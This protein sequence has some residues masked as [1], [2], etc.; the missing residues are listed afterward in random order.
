[1][2]IKPQLIEWLQA[3]PSLLFKYVY[4]VTDVTSRFLRNS[5]TEDQRK[6]FSSLVPEMFTVQLLQI[7]QTALPGS[8][9]ELLIQKQVFVQLNLVILEVIT[10]NRQLFL[11]VINFELLSALFV[12]LSQC[13]SSMLE[14]SKCFDVS[15]LSTQ[16]VKHA[17]MTTVADIV[18]QQLVSISQI[19]LSSPSS[20]SSL[21]SSSLPSSSN[22]KSKLLLSSLLA[23]IETSIP[24]ITEPLFLMAIWLIPQL[25]LQSHHD[26]TYTELLGNLIS[27]IITF[28]NSRLSISPVNSFATRLAVSMMHQTVRPANQSLSNIKTDEISNNSRPNV[29]QFCQI[30]C[31]GND[32]SDP[33]LLTK[34]LSNQMSKSF[35]TLRANRSKASENVWSYEFYPHEAQVQIT[36]ILP[37]D[38]I[39]HKIILNPR[40]LREF[41]PKF[42]VIIK[43]DTASHSTTNYQQIHKALILNDGIVIDHIN[44]R[45]LS[46]KIIM[47]FDKPLLSKLVLQ[48][49]EIC[50][51]NQWWDHRFQMAGDVANLSIYRCLHLLNHVLKNESVFRQQSTYETLLENKQFFSILLSWNHMYSIANS[52]TNKLLIKNSSNLITDLLVFLGQDHQEFSIIILNQILENV[53]LVSTSNS[54]MSG[55]PNLLF[56]NEI[57]IMKLSILYNLLTIEDQFCMARL[58]IVI[59]WFNSIKYQNMVSL[60]S[61]ASVVYLLSVV[62]WHHYHGAF[63]DSVDWSVLF[64]L[65][66]LQRLQM[67]ILNSKGLFRK[68][69]YRLLAS[70]CSLRQSF[71]AELIRVCPIFHGDTQHLNISHL[72]S[73]SWATQS[74]EGCRSLLL[75]GILSQLVDRI[76]LCLY[77]SSASPFNSQQIYTEISEI[78]RFFTK[79]CLAGCNFIKIWL[80]QSTASSFWQPIVEYLINYDH[81]ANLTQASDFSS[82]MKVELVTAVVKFFSAV[83]LCC[84]DNQVVFIRILINVID[85]YRLRSGGL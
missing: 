46:N 17:Q 82:I 26:I 54:L 28:S 2:C 47:R 11:P 49:I 60:D 52:P 40:S 73:I 74:S 25:S 30:S 76:S 72:K 24:T 83:T 3:N 75:S 22:K 45:K 71:Y 85:K 8:I 29:S 37:C 67:A 13:N 58:D 80:G 55:S 78:L 70:V 35:S 62:I 42:E 36:I 48:K 20:S 61:I 64:D 19:L 21:S 53:S 51:I 33:Y 6:C 39:V 69:L 15:V 66:F 81:G 34:L 63:R 7:E 77:P 9:E 57:S 14:S 41:S 50:T 32:S 38:M 23:T 27:S 4:K 79:L 43:R 10:I 18:W 59:K 56:S 16:L 68:S 44:S 12:S 84:H 5:S 1:M 65:P 31:Q